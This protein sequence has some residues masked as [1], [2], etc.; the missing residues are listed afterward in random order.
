M[1]VQTFF[2]GVSGFSRKVMGFQ[3]FHFFVFQ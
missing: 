1:D 3:V 2:Q